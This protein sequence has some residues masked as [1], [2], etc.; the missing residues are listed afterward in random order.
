MAG[1][2]HRPAGARFRGHVRRNGIG[3][4]YWTTCTVTAA[5]PGRE[6]AFQV[7]GPGGAIVNT[8]RYQLEPDASGTRVTESFALPGTPANRVYWL[9]AGWARLPANLRGMRTT[10][11]K[12]KAIAERDSTPPDSTPGQSS[13]AGD[14]RELQ[15]ADMNKASCRPRC[16][17]CPVAD[18]INSGAGPGSGRA[19][20]GTPQ[21][22]APR[23]QRGPAA[24]DGQPRRASRPGCS[25]PLFPLSRRPG[26]GPART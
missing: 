16:G 24:G 26:S 4:V 2:R 5:D 22:P 8:W 13:Q 19:R 18:D 12:I 20:P 1:R 7:N 11:G 14:R 23:P 3:P 21:G 17:Q 9:L 6:F 25:T 10:L 15:A